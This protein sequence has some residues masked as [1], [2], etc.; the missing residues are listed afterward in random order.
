MFPN[1]MWI[2]ALASKIFIDLTFLWKPLRR[3]GSLSYLKYFAMFAFYF[4]IYVLAI[5]FI[6][7]LSKKVIWKERAL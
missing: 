5:P 3:F 7:V 6:A 4:T 1:P 2:G